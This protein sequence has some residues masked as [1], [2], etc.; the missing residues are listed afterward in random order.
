MSGYYELE[1]ANH[2][3]AV[4]A[5]LERLGWTADQVQDWID[6]DPAVAELYGHGGWREW[7]NDPAGCAAW[8]RSR[9]DE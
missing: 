5:E 6:Y 7:Q 2:V 3:Q 8:I 4:R 1:M 9:F